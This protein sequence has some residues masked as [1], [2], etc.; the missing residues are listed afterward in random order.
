M[1]KIRKTVTLKDVAEKTGY[2]INTV[3][4]ALRNKDDISENTK[5][6][7]LEVARQVGY[8]SHTVAVS[9]CPD[10]TNTIALI[11]PDISNPHFAIMTKEIQ[12]KA[13]L[14]GYSTIILDTNEDSTVELLAIKSALKQNVDGIIICPCQRTPE[15][16]RY[17]IDSGIP[18]VEIGRHEIALP[19]SYVVCND[20][21][22]G[23]QA[24]SELVHNGHRRILFLNAPSYISSSR[25]RREGYLKALKEAGI[26]PD[27]ALVYEIP[28]SSG[29]H[30]K[31][32]EKIFSSELNFTAVFAFSDIIAW[33]LWSW[34]L[35]KGYKVPQDYSIVGF[36]YIQSRLPI[37]YQLSTVSSYK[38]KMSIT[39]V[40]TLIERIK[41]SE[42]TSLKN[43][44]L[45][46]I[47]IATK[48]IKGVTVQNIA[49]LHPMT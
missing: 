18:T 37:P 26:D 19:I 38:A 2:S 28:V 42:D 1:K 21:M 30:D 48:F 29:K 14:S 39:A 13:A 45:S 40:E 44:D 20:V 46:C 7:I 25:E 5:L 17:L 9:H 11:L 22:G 47:T 24:T 23:Y 35:S 32:F 27:P 31:T 33:E 43:E 16:I 6:K 15:N 36:D 34:L 12:S 3:S 4:K 10:A 41:S 8:I 49:G